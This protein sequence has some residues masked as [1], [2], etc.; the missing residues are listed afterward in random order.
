MQQQQ[1]SDYEKY[2]LSRR[3]F[4]AGEFGVCGGGDRQA[5]FIKSRPTVISEEE[6]T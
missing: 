3:I 1:K 2:R 5:K 4:D 6:R